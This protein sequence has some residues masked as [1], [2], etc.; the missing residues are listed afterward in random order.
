MGT[1]LLMMD[2]PMV[3]LLLEK[4]ADVYAENFEG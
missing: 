3:K 1:A 2:V 4:G